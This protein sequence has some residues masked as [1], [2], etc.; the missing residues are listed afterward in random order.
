[1]MARDLR[2]FQGFQKIT[3]CGGVDGFVQ[4][5]QPCGNAAVDQIGRTI[6]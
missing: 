4:D 3:Q 6:G 2:R 1:M 5:M